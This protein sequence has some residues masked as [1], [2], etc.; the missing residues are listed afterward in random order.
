MTSLFSSPRAPSA[1]S[2]ALCIISPLVHVSMSCDLCLCDFNE[3]F[4]PA[5]ELLALSPSYPALLLLSPL[6]GW[7]LAPVF[8]FHLVWICWA[9]SLCSFPSMEPGSPPPHLCHPLYPVF[10]C[11][12]DSCKVVSSWGD[13]APA[14]LS[15]VFGPVIIPWDLSVL[16]SSFSSWVLFLSCWNWDPTSSLFVFPF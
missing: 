1:T 2:L 9:H 13:R 3:A 15:F 11:S 7:G 6:L 12:V 14:F 16:P 10:S 4:E 5:F 8:W